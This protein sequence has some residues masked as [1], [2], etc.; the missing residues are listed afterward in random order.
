MRHATEVNVTDAKLAELGNLIDALE[1]LSDD[2]GTTSIP[3]PELSRL[4]NA[5]VGVSFAMARQYTA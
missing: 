5:V 1:V 3:D 4:R 2:L